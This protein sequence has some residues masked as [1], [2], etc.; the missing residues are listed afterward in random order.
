MLA[1]ATGQSVTDYLEN[2]IWHPL[3]MESDAYWLTDGLGVELA[4]FGLDATARDYAKPSNSLLSRITRPPSNWT[5]TGNSK[6]SSSIVD[7]GHY[8]EGASP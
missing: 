7:L 2:R 8:L 1:G 5:P 4:F 3:G 6:L